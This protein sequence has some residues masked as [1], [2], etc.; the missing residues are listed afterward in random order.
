MVVVL[1]T[2]TI[3]LTLTPNLTLD[4]YGCGRVEGQ[5]WSEVSTGGHNIIQYITEQ[6]SIVTYVSIT[7]CTHCP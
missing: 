2:L 6:C 5:G 1:V 4:T 7:F 3:T